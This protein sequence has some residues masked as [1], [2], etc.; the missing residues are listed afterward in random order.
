[1]AAMQ[2]F[3]EERLKLQVNA[4]K[5]A[6]ARP[7]KRTFLGYTLTNAGGAHPAQG[8]AAKRGPP[9]RPRA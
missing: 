8:R 5:S 6:C 1:M 4:A 9:G 7:W 3:L 2:V